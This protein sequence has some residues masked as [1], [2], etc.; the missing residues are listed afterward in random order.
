MRKLISILRYK[1]L[2]GLK[3]SELKLEPSPENIIMVSK[4]LDEFYNVDFGIFP[5]WKKIFMDNN[6][7]FRK[8]LSQY[9]NKTNPMNGIG[10]K[11]EK[12]G[13]KHEHNNPSPEPGDIAFLRAKMDD[14]DYAIDIILDACNNVKGDNVV[15]NPEGDVAIRIIKDGEM[16]INFSGTIKQLIG[17]L[18][19]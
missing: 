4:E 19:P 11:I 18:Q 10:L 17:K 6:S 1:T 14:G 15:R 2:I 7:T 5:E 16:V 3:L 13:E 12:F 8:E 9:L